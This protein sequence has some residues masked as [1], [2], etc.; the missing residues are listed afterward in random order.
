MR[1]VLSNDEIVLASLCRFT[2][3]LLILLSC[4]IVLS[5]CSVGPQDNEN[6]EAGDW[7]L[8]EDLRIGSAATFG[9]ELEQFG[10]VSDIATDSRGRIYVLDWTTDQISVFNSDGTFSHHVGRE[11]QGPGE[12]GG[13]HHLYIGRGDTL[14]IA[15][16]GNS[17]YTR[18]APDGAF[19][20][21]YPRRVFGVPSTTSGGVLPDGSLLD[22]APKLPEGRFGPRVQYVPIHVTIGDS[23]RVDSLP[24]IE[25]TWEMTAGGRLPESTFGGAVAADLDGEG[26]IWF[27]H[28]RDYRL[29]R[30]TLAGDTIATASL[31]FTPPLLEESDREY[32]RNRY[33]RPGLAESYLEN[34]PETK[35][36]IRGIVTDHAGHVFVFPE[37]AD[38]PAGTVVDMFDV[39]GEYL[40]RMRLPTPLKL[41]PAG[42]PTVHAAD[43]YLYLV[44]KDELDVPHVQRLKLMSS[45]KDSARDKASGSS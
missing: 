43:G 44:I 17:R 12:I 36:V 38:E 2:G 40:G 13:A 39:S 4:P 34:V 27:A 18:F 25:Q 10:S 42:P 9:D 22:W 21:D 16:D 6:P 20:D 8:V 7:H 45:N 11:G 3:A 33:S 31:E 14:W 26:R 32:I 28:T 41:G 35:P 29:H 23:L 19:I 15:D 24:Y 30:R 1:P 37:L 5:G